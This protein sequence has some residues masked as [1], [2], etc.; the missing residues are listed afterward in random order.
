[1]KVLFLTTYNFLIT[2][3]HIFTRNVWSS[4]CQQFERN[5]DDICVGTIFQMEEDIVPYV[6]VDEDHGKKYYKLYYPSTFSEAEKVA[7]IARFFRHISPSVIH[8][9]MEEGIEV[10]AARECG[11]PIVLTIHIGG[12]IC[13]RGGVH[14]FLNYKDEIC[15]TKVGSHCLRCCAKDLPLSSLSYFLYR[16]LPGKFLSW[17]YDKLQK[18][19]IFYITQFLRNYN[20]IVLLRGKIETYKYATIIAAN[21]R[22]KQLLALNGLVDNV[23][24]LPHGVKARPKLSLPEVKDIVKFYYV[25]RIQY[26]KGIHNLLSAFEGI[27]KSLYELHIVGDI[28]NSRSSKQYKD[29]LLYLS[30]K[31]NVIFHG[32]IPNE[33]LES[34]L[35]EMHVM[36]HPAIFLEVYGI[37]VAE[38]LAIGRPVLATCCG[39]AEMQIQDGVNGWLVPA[40]DI[41]ALR[42]KIIEI[43]RNKNQ[44]EIKN[45]NC[46]LPHS[47]EEYSRKLLLL[48]EKMI[49]D[50][51]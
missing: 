38:S 29:E 9:N 19:Q 8:S 22:L 32:E 3:E 30:K 46:R 44:I 50:L 15:D 41:I 40:N 6:V 36:I 43:L 16:I 35:R 10:K 7:E 34:V 49:K 39:G 47:L 11:M 45:K 25:G 42:N 4:L 2:N 12:V 51:E 48:Y 28:G 31:K 27:D 24:L 26:A 21:E 17:C 37:T 5:G 33:Q 20:E 13:P 14:G 18:K 23:V 1:M